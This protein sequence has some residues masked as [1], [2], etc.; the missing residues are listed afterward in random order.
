MKH[1]KLLVV[2][3]AIDLALGILLVLFPRRVIEALGLPGA[4]Q[5]F[6]PTVLGG[7]LVGIGIALLIQFFSRPDGLV[8][9][10]LGGAI[11]MN[12]CGSLVLVAWLVSG[13]LEIPP[14]GQAIL[15]GIVVLV[16][17]L[18]TAE[19]AAHLRTGHPRRE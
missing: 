11:A 17:G 6:Y 18:S 1:S 9:L 14:R 7:V 3:A 4:M 13:H 10:G 15:W 8:G 19:L 2:D 5:A 12:L 16:V